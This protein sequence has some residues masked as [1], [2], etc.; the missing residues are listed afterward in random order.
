M[1]LVGAHAF[2]RGTKKVICEQPLMKRDL[3]AFKHGADRDG[4]LLAAIVALD[5]A[6]ALRA[7]RMRLGR[8]AT[9]QRKTLRI[10]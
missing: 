9:L 1:K 2:L 8:T 5:D 3:A 10:E 7:F 4:I 6:L